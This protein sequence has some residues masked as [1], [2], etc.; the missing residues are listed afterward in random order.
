[1]PTTRLKVICRSNTPS[2]YD[3]HNIT[4]E[5]V[6]CGS[7]ENESFWKW[8]PSGRL[9]F[10]TINDQAAAMFKVGKEY[11]VDIRPAPEPKPESTKE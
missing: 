2:D 4:L 3:G 5:P 6:T 7:E 10:G 8:T 11:Y 9:D 1:M